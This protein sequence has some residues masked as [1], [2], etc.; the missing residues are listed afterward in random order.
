MSLA[1]TSNSYRQQTEAGERHSSEARAQKQQREKSCR[2]RQATT[3]LKDAP[4]RATMDSQRLVQR[5]VERGAVIAELLPQLLLRLSLGEMGR[6]RIDALPPPLRA[7]C[8]T[9]R[10]REAGA[11]R[12][13]LGAVPRVPRHHAVVPP[14]HERPRLGLGG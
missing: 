4:R 5:P 14:P 1:R 8:G 7:R 10:G 11:R 2:N 12:R 6:R 3:Y 9:T 13:G